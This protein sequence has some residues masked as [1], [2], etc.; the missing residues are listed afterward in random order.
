M[1]WLPQTNVLFA[2]DV[3]YVDRLIGV[4]PVSSTKNWLATFALVEQL[5]PKIVV[6]GHGAVTNLATARADTQAYLLALR[7]HMKQAV[8][9]GTD[10]SAAVKSFD[11]RPFMRLQNASELMPG[12]AS[13]VYLEIE[14]E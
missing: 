6:P 7:A 1:V 5:D 14:R 12:N 10:I 13:R 8:D 4:I 9:D 3:V 2:G 11:A